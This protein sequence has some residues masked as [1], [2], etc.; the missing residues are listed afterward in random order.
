MPDIVKI[1]YH[2]TGASVSN[3]ENGMRLMA[4]RAF[5]ERKSQYLLIKAPPASGKYRVLMFIT[6]DKIRDQGFKEVINIMKE[7]SQ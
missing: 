3:T 6:L 2:H 5:K 1:E 7:L 4:A